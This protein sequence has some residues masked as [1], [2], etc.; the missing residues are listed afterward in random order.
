MH[1]LLIFLLIPILCL[2]TFQAAKNTL[3]AIQLSDAD[4]LLKDLALDKKE[5]SL[6]KLEKARLALKKVKSLTPNDP[7]YHNLYANA[8]IWQTLLMP[9]PGQQT[10]ISEAQHHYQLGL[11]AQPNNP[12]LW[13]ALAKSDHAVIKQPTSLDAMVQ[14]NFYAPTDH[15]LLSNAV[16]WS[17]PQ[18]KQLSQPQQQKTIKQLKTLLSNKQNNHKTLKHLSKLLSDSGQKTMI[19]SKLSRTKE[20]KRVCYR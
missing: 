17:I 11:Q 3:A 6:S 16:F 8:V 12:Y 13:S 15:T 4:Y 2:L 7:A 20:M 5:A 14:A 1:R 10:N 19:C 9:Q 18:W